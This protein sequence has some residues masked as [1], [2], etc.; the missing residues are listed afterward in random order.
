[1]IFDAILLK[2]QTLPPERILR[3]ILILCGILGFLSSLVVPV[4]FEII[5]ILPRNKIRRQLELNIEL[6]H[7]YESVCAVLFEERIAREKVEKTNV[8]LCRL[9]E[10]RLNFDRYHGSRT[11]AAMRGKPQ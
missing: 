9:N 5:E 11:R 3:G 8:E 7:K 2:F 1:M 6:Q 4:I 10:E